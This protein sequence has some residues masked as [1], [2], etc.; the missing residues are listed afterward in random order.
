MI[1]GYM[2]TWNDPD[3]PLDYAPYRQKH[4]KYAAMRDLALASRKKY[5][6]DLRMYFDKNQPK[7]TMD[8]FSEGDSYP[9]SSLEAFA[10][11]ILRQDA[12]RELCRKCRKKNKD[13]L[14]YGTETGYVE[15]KA[16]YD[17]D[18]N[19]ILDADGHQL[20]LDFPEYECEKGHRWFAGEGE[21]RNWDGPNSV[22]MEEHLQH[23]RRR[24]IYV[25]SEEAMG[26]PDPSI[27]QGIYN[28]SHKDGRKI[29]SKEQ[30][31]KNGASYFR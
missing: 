7:L 12:R 21:R 17:D 31:R 1:S 10:D 14:P 26:K 19:P 28:R 8:D 24:E 30:R 16:Q 5:G 25:M 3:N 22:L 18:G 23:R 15:P 29:N 27:S 20:Y 2:G 9:G 13:K 11:D 6:N 4:T